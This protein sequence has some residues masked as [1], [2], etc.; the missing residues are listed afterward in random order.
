M[1]KQK[2]HILSERLT[3]LG[4]QLADLF[5][6]P[7]LVSCDYPVFGEMRAEVVSEMNEVRGAIQEA[8]AS[9]RTMG[10]D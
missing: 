2:H 7:S 5:N 8:S 3:E 9:Q 6:V 4:G 10:K 1:G